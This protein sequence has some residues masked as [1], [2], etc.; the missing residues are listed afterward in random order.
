ML[1][2]LRCA[3]LQAARDGRED[4]VQEWMV[5]DKSGVDARDTEG[6][7]AFHYAAENHHLNVMRILVD[8]GA[9]L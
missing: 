5:V 6:Y 3:L 7:T 2:L 8:N 1:A 9:G 4:V